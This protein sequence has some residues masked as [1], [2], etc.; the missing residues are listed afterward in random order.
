[1]PTRATTPAIAVLH[2]GSTITVTVQGKGD[3]LLIPVRLA[4]YPEQEADVM[5]QWGAEPELG[6]NLVAALAPEFTVITADY[7]GHRLAFPAPDTLTAA[8][9]AADLRA[10]ADAAGVDRFG[11]YGYSWLALAGLQ[12]AIRT[13]RLWALAMGGFPPIDGPY[14]EMLAVTRAAHRAAAA[15]TA[16]ST[17]TATP[18][19]WD[20]SPGVT[21]EMVTRQF[22][23]LYED[24]FT[25]NDRGIELPPGL[26]KLA[27]A[28][29]EDH[30]EYSERWGG[31]DVKM[32]EPL[33][34][35]EA[36]LEADGWTVQVLPGLDHLGAM[37]SDAALSVLLPWLERVHAQHSETRQ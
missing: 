16:A 10:I 3:A 24:L 31:V 7:E 8:N 6:P 15:P 20:S 23:T 22:A 9:V 21:N 5:R 12:L 37:H 17:T 36:Q 1:M 14:V 18:G 26:A 25:F 33:I 2:D 28:G 13:D 30:I 34:T 4:P 27:F 11:Y 32:A 19:D 29:A 35:H